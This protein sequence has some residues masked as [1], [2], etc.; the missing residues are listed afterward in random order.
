MKAK[1]S[2]L[3][4]R[5]A[6]DAGS[7]TAAVTAGVPN[8]SKFE[9][10][11]PLR[12]PQVPDNPGESIL[13]SS[14]FWPLPAWMATKAPTSPVFLR[15]SLR[16]PAVFEPEAFAEYLRC[17]KNPETIRATC[18]E[19]RVAATLALVHDRATRGRRITMPL[20]ML[21]GQ[22]SSQGSGYDILGVWRDHAENVSGHAIDSGHF[23]P[24]EAPDE[25]YRALRG[26]F[27]A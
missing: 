9:R 27:A 13:K 18:D 11:C 16:D 23:L 2:K 14:S 1:P 3:V 12:V 6:R 7:G 20:L 26:F 25:T 15:H 24:E 22:R 17:F 5:S 8:R 10:S 4:P 21:W 19:Y